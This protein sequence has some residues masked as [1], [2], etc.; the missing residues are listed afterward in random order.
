ME[1]PALPARSLADVKLA[2]LLEGAGCPLCR[3]AERSAA[4]YIHAFLYESVAETRFRAELDRSR[5]FC[6]AHSHQ[7]LAA[8]RAGSGGTLGASILFAAILTIRGRELEVITGSRGRDRHKR[9]AEASRPP[10]CPVCG[11]VDTVVATAIDGFHAQAA[12]D[13]WRDA[14]VRAPFCLDHLV[15]LIAHRP[16]SEAWDGIERAQAAR[17]GDIRDRL[18]RFAKHSSHD[19]RHH[20]TEEERRAADDAAAL[21]GGTPGEL[22][23][24]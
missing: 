7:V 16:A 18:A 1:A 22:L 4:A 12:V 11:T 14:L 21:L 15:A 24:R 13:V 2:Q 5:G 3:Q 9:A 20:L 17:V 23:G 6:R 19:R 10:A 8:N